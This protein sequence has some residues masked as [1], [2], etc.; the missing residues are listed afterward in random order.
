MLSSLSWTPPTSLT[1]RR[2]GERGGGAGLPQK[3]L[4]LSTPATPTPPPPPPPPPSFLHS[5]HY[6]PNPKLWV[7]AGVSHRWSQVVSRVSSPVV[8]GHLCSVSVPCGPV[9]RW[10]LGWDIFTSGFSIGHHGFSLLQRL[11]LAPHTHTHTHTHTPSP[12]TPISPPPERA[13]THTH[14]HPTLLTRD[15]LCCVEPFAGCMQL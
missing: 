4:F 3:A 15:S 9:G 14:T 6:N 8:V 7:E 13:H 10:I 12:D 1:R 11:V 2:P 5:Q